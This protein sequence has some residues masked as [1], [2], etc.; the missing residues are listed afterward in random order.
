MYNTRYICTYCKVVLIPYPF[1]PKRPNLTKW[2]LQRLHIGY[3]EF[4]QWT[5]KGLSNT[6]INSFITINQKI[7]LDNIC[8]VNSWFSV[9]NHRQQSQ[10]WQKML[11]K[12]MVFKWYCL[13]ILGLYSYWYQLL[14]ILKELN[15]KLWNIIYLLYYYYLL[16]KL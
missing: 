12:V 10:V 6:N 13:L 4:L 14:F 9:N 16:F 11:K 8:T 5:L 1:M 7:I 2:P 3:W 15:Y